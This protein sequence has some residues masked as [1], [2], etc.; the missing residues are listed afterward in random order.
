MKCGS[1]CEHQKNRENLFL[2]TKYV[3]KSTQRLVRVTQCPPPPFDCLHETTKNTAR[4]EFLLYMYTH[5]KMRSTPLDARS[6]IKRKS[7][8][9]PLFEND[10]AVPGR[11]AAKGSA[12]IIALA[13]LIEKQGDR[14]A[15]A[16]YHP[17]AEFVPRVV[18]YFRTGLSAG[19]YWKSGAETP[20]V[21]PRTVVSPIATLA[22]PCR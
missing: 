11:G 19:S 6:V 22:F 8:V 18:M 10:R 3:W 1:C 21:V 4:V 17:P 5:R 2:S 20:L 7:A 9:T 14:C 16:T 12:I 15:I 13:T